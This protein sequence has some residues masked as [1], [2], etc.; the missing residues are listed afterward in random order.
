MSSTVTPLLSRC[1]AMPSSAPTVTTPVPPTPVTTMPN[2]P[3]EHR[4]DGLRQL[5]GLTHG[6]ARTG[7]GRPLDLCAFGRDEARTEAL[8]AGE[9]LL[10][11]DWLILRLVPSEVSSGSTDR[12]L[13][14]T[15][16]SPQP[17]QTASLIKVRR[18]G[19]GRL[20]RLRRRR[21]S[22]AQVCS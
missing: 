21:F 18:A 6:R 22:V 20:P 16:Q 3:V 9:S 13:D 2:G 12:Q 17:S 15:E 7:A 5:V 1:A 8:Q 19:S 10:H 11:D 4:Q 14:A